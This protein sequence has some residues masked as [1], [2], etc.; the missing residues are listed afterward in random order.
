MQLGMRIYYEKQTGNVIVNTGERTGDVVE[1][2]QEQDFA[3][4][5]V[6]KECVP[7][8]VG[9]IQLEYGEFTADYAEGGV[10]TQIDLDTL[11]PLFTYPER[12]DTETPLEPVQRSVNKWKFWRRTT[13]S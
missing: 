2:T 7:E 1:T 4:Y 10:I 3:A 6:L 11:E 12:V 9:M 13:H 8:T 5:F